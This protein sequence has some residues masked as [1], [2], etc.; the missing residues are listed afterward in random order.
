MHKELRSL[1]GW[2]GR[3]RI[4]GHKLNLLKKSHLCKRKHMLRQSKLSISL[5]Y[6]ILD[7]KSE[8][9]KAKAATILYS[10]TVS[11]CYN[12]YKRGIFFLFFN[13]TLKIWL[14][15]DCRVLSGQWHCP[16][17]GRIRN[18]PEETENHDNI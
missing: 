1:M 11:K 5:V 13:T 9:T 12:Y 17:Y 14:Y 2:G 18:Y 15:E 8:G 7:E 3:D 10:Y 4:H 6:G 16:A